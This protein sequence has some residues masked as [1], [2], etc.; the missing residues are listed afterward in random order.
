MHPRIQDVLTDLETNRANLERA[1]ASVPAELHQS[2][3]AADRWS[4]AEIV[5]HVSLVDARIAA[6]LIGQL[7]AARAA[8][9]GSEGESAPVAPA[10][11]R[12]FV[13]ERVKRLTAG[14]ASQPRGGMTTDAA[15]AALADQRRI[16]R[17]AIVAAD[18]LALST[19]KIP[20]PVLGML[21]VYDWLRFLGGHETRHAA[22]I[23]EAGAAV[24]SAR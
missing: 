21:D 4:V 7:D 13:A 14:E 6:L 9:L 22:Q 12:A 10:F 24:Q 19:V 3:P 1:V 17:E 15:L 11:D 18:G 16:L 2:R 20:H 23:R 5:E 8:G